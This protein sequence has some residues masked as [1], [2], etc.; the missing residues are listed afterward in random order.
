MTLGEFVAFLT[1]YLQLIWP[2]ITWGWLLALTQVAASAARRIFE[3]IDTES[4]ILDPVESVVAERGTTLHFENV[5]FRY[6]G[7]DEDV[8]RGIDLEVA[9]G[10]TM[11]LVGG[12]GSGKTDTPARWSAG[13]TTVTGGRVLLAGSMCASCAWINCATPSPRRS[14]E[15]TLFSAGVAKDLSLPRS[16]GHHRRRR[17]RA[18]LVAEPTPSQPPFG[19]DTRIGEQGMSLSGGQRQRLAL[20]RAVLGRPRALVLDDPLSALDVH[21]EKLRSRRRCARCSP[22]RQRWWSR[23]GRRP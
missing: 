8:L 1:L 11:A 19:L 22:A 15:A 4:T 18:I 12:V 16:L 14:E 5:L 7:A 17:H 20:A 3:V 2:I 21:T 13:S 9:A 6:E 10:G 23:T